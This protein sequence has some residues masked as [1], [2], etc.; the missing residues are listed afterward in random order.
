MKTQIL[1]GATAL[2][3]AAGMTSSAMA[4]N[5]GG[6]GGGN[7]GSF[8]TGSV[9]AMHSYGAMQGPRMGA[10]RSFG[11]S[12][13]AG[14]RSFGATPYAGNRTFGSTRYAGVRGYNG[15]RHGRRFVGG[16]GGYGGWDYPYYDTYAADV[17][18]GVVGLGVGLA[19]V[20]TGY[21]DPYAYGW[22]WGA[23]YCGPGYAVDAWSW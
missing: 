13:Y 11:T 20:A 15:W 14:T 6:R 5:H 19:E 1:A 8:R 2:V 10:V 18:L 21:C 7:T 23:G 12:G 3:L 16:W 9:G 17:G 4:F 22:G